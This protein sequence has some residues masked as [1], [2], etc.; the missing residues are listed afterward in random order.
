MDPQYVFSTEN[1]KR[2]KFPTHIN[3]LVVDRAQASHSEVFMVL[4]EP[5]K[6]VHHHKHDDTEQIFFMIRGTGILSIGE[7][8]KEYSLKPGDVVRMPVSTLHSIRN[9]GNVTIQYLSI[10]CF[11]PKTPDEPTWD[12]HARAMCRENGWDYDKV[13]SSQY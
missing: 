12:E 1:L 8:K 10:D 5:G 3:D 2:Y 13:I 9:D 7:E 4:V 11:G 6:S